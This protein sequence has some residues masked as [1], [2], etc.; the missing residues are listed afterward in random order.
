MHSRPAA[1]AIIRRERKV[2]LV[3]LGR[4]SHYAG[5]WTFPGGLLDA[6]ESM[7]EAATREVKEETNLDLTIERSFWRG[8][9]PTSGR[10]VE[11]FTGTAIGHLK[12]QASELDEAVWFEIDDALMIK[13][14]Y[15]CYDR[16]MELKLV[17]DA[18]E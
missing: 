2:L 18:S 14:A 3:R 15:Q 16:L 9:E 8:A 5:F 4:Y 7:A 13:L 17:M 6:G 1:F 11:I 12:V 10:E